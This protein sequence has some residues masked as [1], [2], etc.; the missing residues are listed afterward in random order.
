MLTRSLTPLVELLDVMRDGAPAPSD[1]TSASVLARLVSDHH[2]RDQNRPKVTWS[3]SA[4]V[5]V[6]TRNVLRRWAAAQADPRL[7]W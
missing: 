2:D 1:G 7:V 5:R 4:R 3:T 6:R